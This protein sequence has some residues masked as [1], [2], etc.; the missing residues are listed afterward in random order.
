MSTDDIVLLHTLRALDPKGQQ[1]PRNRF[2]YA[3]VERPSPTADVGTVDV[4]DLPV[5]R[6]WTVKTEARGRIYY[7][8]VEACDAWKATSVALKRN[9]AAISA[10]VVREINREEFE[11]LT[12][13]PA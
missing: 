8:H 3:P 10:Q 1:Q 12:R 6:Y 4:S 5:I 7:V 13:V 9:S 11:H 2:S